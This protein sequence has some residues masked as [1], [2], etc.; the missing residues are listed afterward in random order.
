MTPA[1]AAQAE[2]MRVANPM[3]RR[4]VRKRLA[5]ALAGRAPA[6]R[7]GNGHGPLPWPQRAIARALRKVDRAWRIERVVKTGRGRAYPRS[8]VVDVAHPSL[9]IAVEVDGRSHRAA[10]VIERDRAKDRLLEALG[11]VVI[12]LTNDNVREDLGSCVEA[13]MVEV[14]ARREEVAS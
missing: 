11:W 9:R 13:V 3:R 2:R 14:E 4:A 1:Q 5:R 10:D 12:R 8:Y 7:R 6:V